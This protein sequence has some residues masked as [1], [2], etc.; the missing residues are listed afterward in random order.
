MS[1]QEN[2]ISKSEA[3]VKIRKEWKRPV[4]VELEE[5]NGGGAEGRKGTTF[6]REGIVY[7]AS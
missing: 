5:A 7:S 3:D 1:E 2:Q 6:R 4:V